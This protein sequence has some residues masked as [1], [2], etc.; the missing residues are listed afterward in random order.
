MEQNDRYPSL[1]KISALLKSLA[2]MS[3][4]ATVVLSVVMST[5]VPQPQPLSLFPMI[6]GMI[7]F[8]A[9]LWLIAELIPLFIDIEHNTRIIAS[10]LSLPDERDNISR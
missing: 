8:S 9:I 6:F 2:A 3:A 10:K 1:R 5:K 4:I 7:L